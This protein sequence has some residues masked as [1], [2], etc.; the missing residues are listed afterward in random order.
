MTPPQ[1]DCPGG[2]RVGGRH[3]GVG[4]AAPYG[5]P[6]NGRLPHA[7]PRPHLHRRIVGAAGGKIVG[8]DQAHRPHARFRRWIRSRR[9]SGHRRSGPDGTGVCR[10]RNFSSAGV[11]GDRLAGGGVHQIAAVAAHRAVGAVQPKPVLGPAAPGGQDVR[12]GVLVNATGYCRPGARPTPAAVLPSAGSYSL[13]GAAVVAAALQ[14]L[15]LLKVELAVVG[16]QIPGKPLI[17]DVVGALDQLAALAGAGVAAVTSDSTVALCTA[18]RRTAQ[19]R[20]AGARRSHSAPSAA[21]RRSRSQSTLWAPAAR[22]AVHRWSGR[23][24]RPLCSGRLAPEVI[25]PYRAASSQ[26][27]EHVIHTL[28]G[29]VDAGL[30]VVGQPVHLRRG[31]LLLPQAVVVGLQLPRA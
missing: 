31:A 7:S 17:R 26:K 12:V 14:G 5:L 9:A 11:M 24:G 2:W 29:Q 27:S 10:R 21:R 30:A 8:G 16:A 28:G 6:G 18:A 22:T 15:A 13:Q 25:T 19:S 4:D 20:R 1:G 23:R 3:R